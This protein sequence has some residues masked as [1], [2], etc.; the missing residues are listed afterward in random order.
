MQSACLSEEKCEG[1]FPI[2][3]CS[4]NFIIIQEN[5]TKE[6]KQ[7]ENCVYIGGEKEELVKLTDEFLYKIIGIK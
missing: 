2:K 7:T 3:T 4:D 6:I 5:K 1:D